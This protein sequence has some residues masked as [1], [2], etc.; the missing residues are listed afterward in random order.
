[1]PGSTE[2]ERLQQFV[3]ELNQGNIESVRHYMSPDYF[4]YSPKEDEPKAND[5]YYGILSDINTA[6]PDLSIEVADLEAKNG[7][8][9]GIMTL[10]GTTEGPLWGA[11]PTNKSA[12]WEV[13]IS[14]RSADGRFAVNFDDVTVPELIGTLRQIDM[15]PP[16]DRMDRPH[17]YPVQVPEPILQALFNGGMA[18][19]ACDHLQDIQISETDLD[20]CHHCVDQ[21]DVWPALR[22]C[23]ICGFVGCCDTSTNKHMKQHYEETGH[24]IFRSIRLNEGWGWCYEDNA[25]FTSRRLRS[26][27]PDAG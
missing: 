27:Y 6:M 20:V 4:H 8:I 17:I 1:M 21:G 2:I 3:T 11:P 10:K 18:E 24:A 19:V 12:S 9:T 5:V 25:F 16:P 13:N 15:V 14:V 7:L 22:M 23:L 26:H